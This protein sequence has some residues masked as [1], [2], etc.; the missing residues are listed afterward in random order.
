MLQAV[1]GVGD[2]V[3]TLPFVLRA[4]KNPFCIASKM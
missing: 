1:M 4:I 3:G 2:E